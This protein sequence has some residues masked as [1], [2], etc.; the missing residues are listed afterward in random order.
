MPKVITGSTSM[1]IPSSLPA[2][3]GY[4]D[5]AKHLIGEDTRD[6]NSPP[7]EYMSGGTRYANKIG[8]QTEFKNISTMGNGSFLTGT[9][10]YVETKTPWENG[11]GGYPIQIAYGAGRPCWRVGTSEMMWSAW[12]AFNDGGNANTV[13]GFTVAKSVPSDAKFTDT[14]YTSLPANGG[15]ADTVDGVHANKFF[16]LDADNGASVGHRAFY[17]TDPNGGYYNSAI[18]VREV[19]QVTTNQSSNAYAPAIGFHWGG[20]AQGRLAI[21]V[22]GV[23]AWSTNG[24]GDGYNTIWHAGNHG[25]GSGLSA[26]NVDGKH[27]WV[28]AEASKGSDA[29]TIYFCY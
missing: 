13:N 8:W 15:N 12:Q 21:T 9:Y 5:T 14:T 1:N 3:G 24:T 26:D 17:G 23:L 25:S 22:N 27:V 4:A 29:N 2:N 20:R 16:R 6:I 11:S 10:C 7:S 19:N 18:E 28:G